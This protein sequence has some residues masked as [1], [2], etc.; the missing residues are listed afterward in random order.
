MSAEGCNI[1]C[2]SIA[3]SGLKPASSVLGKHRKLQERHSP[4][5]RKVCCL[6]KEKI[7]AT[8][9]EVPSQLNNLL[10]Q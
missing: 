5:S 4:L 7:G 1:N 9:S 8:T 2:S 3:P 6:L 10:V